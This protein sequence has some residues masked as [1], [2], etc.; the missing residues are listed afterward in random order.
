MH[1]FLQIWKLFIRKSSEKSSG[2]G[3]RLLEIYMKKMRLIIFLKVIRIIM[4]T[5]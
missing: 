3:I 4:F 5:E 1:R 2:L